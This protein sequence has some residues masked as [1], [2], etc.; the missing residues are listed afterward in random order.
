[1]RKLDLSKFSLIHSGHTQQMHSRKCPVPLYRLGITSLSCSCHL[2]IE[3]WLIALHPQC[4]VISSQT[5]K[6]FRIELYQ[7]R[8]QLFLFPYFIQLPRP[9]I[10]ECQD[11]CI[12]QKCLLKPL[13]LP[14]SFKF[15]S[16][17][18]PPSELTSFIYSAW[19]KTPSCSELQESW[20]QLI[21]FPVDVIFHLPPIP[22]LGSWGTSS[23]P[24]GW[25]SLTPGQNLISPP[26][27]DGWLIPSRF[28]GQALPASVSG[29]HQADTT[30]GPE[31]SMALFL[32]LTTPLH[33]VSSSK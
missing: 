33:T 19:M 9:T 7:G 4:C 12:L 13:K 26:Q 22:P 8:V 20:H 16:C 21:F 11:T 23:V 18:A 3:S 28:Q 24:S 29:I 5:Y 17:S 10:K 1:M 31:R 14:S 25:M 15:L 32:P 2:Q 27:P 6:L 30:E